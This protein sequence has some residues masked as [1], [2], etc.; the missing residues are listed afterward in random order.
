MINPFLWKQSNFI[1]GFG[2]I[3]L[4]APVY[5]PVIILSLPVLPACQCFL[6]AVGEIGFKLDLVTALEVKILGQRVM[7]FL[8]ELSKILRHTINK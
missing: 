1:E 4:L 7:L 5:I 3:L 8:D 6:D 2:D